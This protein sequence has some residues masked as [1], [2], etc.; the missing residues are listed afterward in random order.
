MIV[1]KKVKALYYKLFDGTETMVAN[2]IDSF[3]ERRQMKKHVRK[4][5]Q[6]TSDQKKAVKEFWK[7]YGGIDS[8][9]IRFYT[10]ITGVFDPRYIPTD[11]EDTKIDQFFN[12]R[13]LGWGFN[14]KNYYSL[15]F[16]GIRQPKTVVRKIG[17]LF[18][19]EEYN[20]IDWKQA[21][22]LLA[23]RTEVVVKPSQES[24]GGRD[25]RFFNTH[26]QAEELR[27]VL[28]DKNEKNLIVQE[29]VKQHPELAKMHPQS[30]NTIR[31]YTLLLDDGVHI[32]PSAIRMGA[33]SNR[34]DNATSRAG[35]AAGINEDGS[36]SDFAVFDMYTGIKTDHHPQGMPLSEIHVPYFD[37]MIETVKRAAQYIANFRLVGWDLSADEEGNIILIEANMRKGGINACQ[38]FSGPF[39]GD[40]TEKVLNMV[41]K[42]KE[43]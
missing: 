31:I 2:S 32:L 15:M 34:I 8:D 19:D 25:I 40:M 26:K 42:K 17:G 7:P 1:N 20:Q 3:Y 37:K 38:M 35:I 11:L 29:I 28:L 33:G 4:M 41:F 24:G 12:N 23:M 6:L 27:D 21:E 30:L 14:D 36:L 43:K 10:F 13:K 16:P 9:W 18:F 22:S 39:F 5:P